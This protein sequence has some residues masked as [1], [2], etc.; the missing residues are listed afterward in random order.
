MSI[1]LAVPA[2]T[3]IAFVLVAATLC[4][5]EKV[6][7]S[8]DFPHSLGTSAGQEVVNSKDGMSY[9]WI[10]PG[11]FQMGCSV[12]D[13]ECDHM[14]VN[15]EHNLSQPLDEAPHTLKIERGF[16]MGQ[17]VITVGAWKAHGWPLKLDILG[18]GAIR[19]GSVPWTPGD[20][21]DRQ[22]MI[23][24]T[25]AEAFNFCSAE[26]LR[27]PTEAEWEYA[28][29]AGTTEARYGKLDNIAWY[30]DNSGNQRLDAV[31]QWNQA[32]V[33]KHGSPPGDKYYAVLE[34][35]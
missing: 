16:W 18:R 22:P 26:G 25:W 9:V 35:I 10:P 21:D 5:Q 30:A 34:K 6:P 28:A 24:L 1:R 33:R 11:S 4:A 20:G 8:M 17:T 19:T 29:R 32:H 15:F 31:S 2:C 7:A 13:N 12:N 3:Q 27:L 23:G 14:L